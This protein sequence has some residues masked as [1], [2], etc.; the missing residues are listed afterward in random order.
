M[1][2]QLLMVISILA[3]VFVSACGANEANGENELEKI[4]F[5]DAGWDSIRVH[6][7]IAATILEEGYGYKTDVTA[8]STAATFQG[9]RQGDIQVYM[10]VWTNNIKQVYNEALDQGE[11]KEVS[12]NFDDNSS[13]LWV[14]TYVIEGDKERGIEPIA[15]GLKTV[16]D[17]KNYAHIFKDPEQPEKGRIIGAPSGWE[18]SKIIEQKVETYGLEATY[19]YFRPG[20]DSAIVSSLASAYKS[21]EPWVGYYWSP[22]WVTSLYDMTLLQEPEY[23]PE[24]WKETKGTQ[25]PPN[26]VTVAVH[27]A[28]ATQAPEIV[29]F[30]SQYK[31]SS[32]LTGDALVY[33]EKNDA[34]PKETANWWLKKHQ[35]VWGKWVEKEVKNKVLKAIK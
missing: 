4:I 7:R 8:G 10:E 30:L 26:T 28:L 31:T 35:D 27:Q 11:V 32:Q 22:T 13:G 16:E 15:P 12:V 2:K 34:S 9:L 21:G 1:K 14:P 29:D 3:L 25:T 6:N 20:S 18:S 24:V 17:L 33:L 5:A 23:D 19:N